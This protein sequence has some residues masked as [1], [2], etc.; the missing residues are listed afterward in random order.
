MILHVLPGVFVTDTRLHT[1]LVEVADILAIASKDLVLIF[2]FRTCR[3]VVDILQIVLRVRSG[4]VQL[5]LSTK[6]QCLSNAERHAVVELEG[7]VGGL[8]LIL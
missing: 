1:E 5:E 3:G 8:V 7:V 4:V 6:A 2:I